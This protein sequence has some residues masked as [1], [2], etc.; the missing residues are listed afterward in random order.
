[1]RSILKAMACMILGFVCIG[2]GFAQAGSG[3]PTPSVLTPQLVATLA[4]TGSLRCNQGQLLEA[5]HWDGLAVAVELR[6]GKDLHEPGRQGAVLR[7]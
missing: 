1:M 2:L 6:Y 7:D 5:N 3:E 4:R